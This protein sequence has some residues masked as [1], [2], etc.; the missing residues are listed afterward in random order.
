MTGV[1]TRTRT[2]GHKRGTGKSSMLPMKAEFGG[3]G[4]QIK[5]LQGSLATTRRE[6]KSK[7]EFSFRSSFVDV[8]VSDFWPPEF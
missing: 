5:E 6:G 7:N 3:I 8:L 4:L 1:L 2:F